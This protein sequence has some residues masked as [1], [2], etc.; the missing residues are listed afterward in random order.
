MLNTI[1][2]LKRK[3]KFIQLSLSP[4]TNHLKKD[5]SIQ[6]KWLGNDYGGFYVATEFL[7]KNSI[8]YSF[9]IGEDI[10]FDEEMIKDNNCLVFGFDPTPK[11]INWIKSRQ[12]PENFKFYSSGIGDKT[13]VDYF[14]LPKNPNYVSGSLVQQNNVDSDSKIEVQLQSLQDIAHML[15]HKKIDVLKMDIEGFE[16]NVIESILNS[17]VEIGQILVEVHERFFEN[18]QQRTIDM[19]EKLRKHDF[20]VFGIS[21]TFEEIS[22]INKNLINNKK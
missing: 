18:G 1:H 19:L 9:G 16:Y 17:N 8:V 20:L 6:K 11:S 13:T 5:I 21:E 3:I 15:E 10:S 14:Y 2:K 22:L 7:D 4:T 12:V